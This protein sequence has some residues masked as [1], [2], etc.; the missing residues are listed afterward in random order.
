MPTSTYSPAFPA[1]GLDCASDQTTSSAL[2]PSWKKRRRKYAQPYRPASPP[3]PH[4]SLSF[5]VLS[6]SLHPDIGSLHIA[7]LN[8]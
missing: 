8:P 3:V 1:M 7:L 5:T 6:Y 2:G 4:D